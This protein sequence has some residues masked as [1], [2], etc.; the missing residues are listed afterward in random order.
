MLIMFVVTTRAFSTAQYPDKIIYQGKEYSLHSNPLESFFEKHPERK[1]RGGVMSTAL[2]RGYVAT[3][4]VRDGQ[5]FL[6]DIEI[7]VQDS[8]ST[9]FD[10]VWKS[11]R[12]KVFPNQAEIKIDW[13]S[14]L[15]VIPH[16]KLVNY[17]HMGY[18]STYENYI[19]LEV[20]KGDVK[21]ERK[22]G[23]KEYA[24]FRERQFQAFRETPEY[25]DMK[26]KLMEKGSSEEFVDSFLRDFVIQYTGRLLT[27]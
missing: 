22:Y 6:K 27:E 23:H 26:A 19:L 13:L 25:R 5:L 24:K 14:G 8:T 2:W 21:Q 12:A 3:F 11:V 7:Q 18:G 4:E 10:T 16:G 1:P 15:L 9:D 20:D 17:V